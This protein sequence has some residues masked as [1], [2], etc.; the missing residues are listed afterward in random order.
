M[1]RFSPSPVP[2]PGLTS[3]ITVILGLVAGQLAA[4]PMAAPGALG[5]GGPDLTSPC[6]DGVVKDDGSVETGWGWVPSVIEG[7]YVQEFHRDEFVSPGLLEACICWLR[8][9]NDADISFDVV[10]YTDVEGQPA[11]EPFAVVPAT[12]TDVPEGIVGAFTKVSLA[13]IDLPPGTFYIGPRWDPSTDQ[14]FFVC[15][16]TTEGNPVTDVWFIDDRAEEWSSVLETSDPLFRDHKAILVRPVVRGT[17]P[18]EVPALP[19]DGLVLL[20]LLLAIA[21]LYW[22]LRARR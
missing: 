8:T 7:Q 11:E 13:G 5:G 12:A 21:G 2:G 9:N 1:R 18:V 15:A 19:V 6:A 10:L 17:V 16:D 20:A 22:R 4:Q 3:A 14:F